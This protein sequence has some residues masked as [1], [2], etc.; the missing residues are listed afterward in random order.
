MLDAAPGLGGDQGAAMAGAAVPFAC[1]RIEV[2]GPCE[3]VMWAR[4]R[5]AHEPAAEG[6]RRLDIEL[7]DKDG[8]LRVAFRDLSLRAMAPASVAAPAPDAAEPPFLAIGHWR[9]APLNRRAEPMES[10]VVLAGLEADPAI[11]ALR[12]PPPDA[13]DIAATV[14]A[15]FAALHGRVA[16]ILRGKPRRRQQ[17]LVLVAD[18]LPAFM[19]QPLAA[20]L[21]AAAIEQPKLDGALVRV[22]G[23][24]TPE[25]QTAIVAGE[26]HRAD[27]WPEVRYD[28]ATGA[29]AWRPE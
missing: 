18:D 2:F 25:R 27:A 7:M 26:R 5:A 16:D 23:P 4:V 14:A 12:L 19:I 8:G 21:K 10:V 22:A 6:L 9:P 1:R 15:W 3:A 24:L 28:E 13:E 29:W 20:L 11:E 17:V